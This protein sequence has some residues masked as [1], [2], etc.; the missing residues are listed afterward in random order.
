MVNDI[1]RLVKLG[2]L[3]SSRV[4]HNH[5]GWRLISCIWL[6]AGVFHILANMLSLLFIGVKLEQEFGLCKR[7]SMACPSICLTIVVLLDAWSHDQVGGSMAIR[8]LKTAFNLRSLQLCAVKIGLLY[9]LSGFGGSLLSTLFLQSRISVGASGAVFGLMGSMLS[10]LITNWTIYNNKVH[11]SSS[12]NSL[13]CILS[14]NLCVY[15]FFFNSALWIFY[16]NQQNKYP[17]LEKD[18]NK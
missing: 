18:T 6:H 11:D 12:S 3:D 5:Q 17:G 9:L 13:S 4:V 2:A 10:E 15:V 14:A 8:A 7:N 16:S 1:C